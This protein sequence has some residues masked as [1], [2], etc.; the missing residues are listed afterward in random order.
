MTF[1]VNHVGLLNLL[2]S[3]L[4]FAWLNH[5][6]DITSRSKYIDVIGRRSVI[7]YNRIPKTGSTTL[8]NAIA[9]DLCA[10]NG[11]HVAHL[12]LTKNRFAMN[13]VDQATLVR[14]I[15]AWTE[16]MPAFYH[17]H[18]AFVDFTKFG[19]PNP[20]YINM[21]REPFERHVSHYY[22][23]RYGDDYRVGLKRSRAGNNETFDECIDRNGKDCDPKQMWLQVPFF[24]GALNFCSQPGN[25]K[26]L[27]TA[28]WNLQNHYLLV[29]LTERMEDAIVLL[30][31]LLPDYFGGALQHFKSLN[32]NRAHL[33]HTTMKIAPS[34]ST[35]HKVKASQVYQM[36]REF[37]DF[38]VAEF[39]NVW[40]RAHDEDGAIIKDQY[41]FEK[42][43]P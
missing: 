40:R 42:I 19:H 8:T 9:Y 7:L 18:V 11:F 27:E 38:A 26:A 21:I 14:N 12:N 30:E 39:E 29:G 16:M 1:R 13:L 2:L 37:Y 3:V 5:K 31:H 25:A 20:I 43:R 22:F 36:E 17:G 24:C 33:R 28:K 23:L 32:A 6:L 35:V 10:E 4:I 15:S 41:H 34:P